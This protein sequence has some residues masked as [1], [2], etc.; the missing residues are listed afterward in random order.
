MFFHAGNYPVQSRVI[1]KEKALIL[2]D[3]YRDC[4]ASGIAYD[5]ILI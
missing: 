4:L 2:A 1:F 3:F 5:F